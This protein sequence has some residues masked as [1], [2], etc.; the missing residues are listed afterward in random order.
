[1]K[2]HFLFIFLFLFSSVY[3][4]ND[5]NKEENN[6]YVLIFE[7]W[8]ND[9]ST[10]K[11]FT[12]TN[13]ILVVLPYERNYRRVDLSET[14]S[15]TVIIHSEVN[16]LR[17]EHR[18][19]YFNSIGFM[20]NKGDTIIVKKVD[21]QPFLNV[22]NRTSKPYDLN[23]NYYRNNRYGFI[24]GYAMNSYNDYMFFLLPMPI[25]KRHNEDSL[26][27]VLLFRLEGL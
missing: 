5:S 7:N 26:M 18:Y 25:D 14:M 15:D 27:Q 17:V 12:V 8:E 13:A 10:Y 20:I 16:G 21:N 11:N 23:Y 1:M 3:C 24:D 22:K 4:S 2:L 19:N 6:E 9:Y